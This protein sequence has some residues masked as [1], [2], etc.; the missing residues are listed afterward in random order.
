MFHNPLQRWADTAALTVQRFQLPA[1]IPLEGVG[2][3]D[4][5]GLIPLQM[6]SNP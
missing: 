3:T 2:L 6:T 1:P 5:P 4:G